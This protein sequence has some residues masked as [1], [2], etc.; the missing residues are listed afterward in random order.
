[1]DVEVRL[2]EKLQGVLDSWREFSDCLGV[3][4]SVL[5][6]E[7]GNWSLASGFTTLRPENTMPP[8]APCFIYSITKTFSAVA[9]LKLVEHGKLQLNEPVNNYL[10]YEGLEKEIKVIHLLNHTSGV[11][12]YVALDRVQAK[13]SQA[14]SMPIPDDEVLRE[15]LVLSPKD[16]RPGGGWRYSNT[17]YMLV[18]KLIEQVT[19]QSYANAIKELLIDPLGLESTFVADGP[20]ESTVIAGYTRRFS[21]I[22]KMEDMSNR[23]DLG[24]VKT[25]LIVSNTSDVALFF[26]NVFSGKFLNDESLEQMT[27]IRSFEREHNGEEVQLS[28]GLGIDIFTNAGGYQEFGHGGG[29]PGF[30]TGCKYYAFPDNRQIV[31]AAFCN[32]SMQGSLHFL[33][34]EILEALWAPRT[35]LGLSED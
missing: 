27:R 3:N 29:G 25:G 24:W 21:P 26:K 23:Y 14:C 22:G 31:L 1:M 10:G 15:T 30:T 7:R 34:H 2:E 8:N 18:K 12:D 35:R 20:Y 9:V 16:F 5:D 11:P 33:F 28:Y 4:L 19:G 32:T 17:G 13:A 6:S